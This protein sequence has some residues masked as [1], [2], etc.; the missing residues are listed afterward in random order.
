MSDV[1]VTCHLLTNN[2]PLNAVVPAA[3]IYS[4]VIPLGT[5]APAIGI[6]HISTIRTHSISA[7]G[8]ELCRSRVQVTVQAATYPSQKA[9]LKLVREAL[10]NTRGT[11]ASVD[12]DSLLHELDGPDWYDDA[13]GLYAGSVD[14]MVIFNE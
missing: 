10:P 8:T 1:K 4:G 12:L 5:Q 7:S 13:S 6:S 3:K 11:I 2:A 14:Y 9:I